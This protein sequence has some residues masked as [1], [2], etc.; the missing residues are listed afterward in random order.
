MNDEYP[1]HA[2]RAMFWRFGK[3]LFWLVS[4]TMDVRFC[5]DALDEALPGHDRP[6]IFNTGLGHQFTSSKPAY[7][8]AFY[9]N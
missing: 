5:L 2:W 9:D 3:G 6:Q 8:R 1:A 4:N 7:C